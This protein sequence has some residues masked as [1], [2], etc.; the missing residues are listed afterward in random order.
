MISLKPRSILQLTIMGF[1][2]I[3]GILLVT[4]IVTARQLDGLS[5]QSQRII[6]ESA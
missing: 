1:L 2:T 5:D 3:T 6:S 4:L